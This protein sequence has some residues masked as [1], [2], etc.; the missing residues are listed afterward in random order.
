[1]IFKGQDFNDILFPVHTLKRDVDIF[2]AFPKLR[3]Y[4][5]FNVKLPP[6]LPFD[7]VFKYLVFVYDQ[8]SPYYLQIEDLVER[9]KQAV[10]DAGFAP[11]HKK[12]FSNYVKQMLN[13]ENDEINKMI[14]RYCRLQSKDFTNLIASQEAFYQI[15]IQLLKGISKLDED[16][17]KSAKLK[18]QL[19]KEAEDFNI[20]LN[21]KARRFL[22][23]ETNEHL[24]KELWDTAG[25]EAIILKLTP[26]DNA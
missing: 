18:A 20:R 5:E 25:E 7:K 15:N 12:G 3:Q 6:T 10:I 13:C 17:T 23:Q 11:S 14:I 2:S 4:E 22:S 1:M 24:Q 26:E 21:D 16:P 19:D 9:K 8:K